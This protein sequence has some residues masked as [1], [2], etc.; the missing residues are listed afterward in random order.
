LICKRG[1]EYASGEKLEIDIVE[2]VKELR[3]FSRDVSLVYALPSN[4][5]GDIA[6]E[7]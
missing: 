1:E 2:V 7:T 4:K 3:D 6:I 5:C